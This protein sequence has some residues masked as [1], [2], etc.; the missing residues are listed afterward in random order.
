VADDDADV[1]GVAAEDLGEAEVGA[2]APSEVKIP[3]LEAITPSVLGLK[4]RSRS[5]RAEAASTKAAGNESGFEPATAAEANREAELTA[6]LAPGDIAKTVVVPVSNAVVSI[7]RALGQVTFT[8]AQLPTSKTP[9]TDVIVSVSVMV[10][11]V[12]GAV[13]EVA[14][15]PGD[16]VTLLGANTPDYVQPPLIGAGG[17]VDRLIPTPVDVPLLAPQMSQSAQVPVAAVKAP[18]ATVVPPSN[19]GAVA[20]T[21]LKNELSLSGL[22][23]VRSSISPATTSFLDH[24]VSSVLAPASLTALAAIAL[25]GLGGLLIVCA[26]GIRVGYRQAKAGLALRA[27]G[28]AR[29]AGPGPMGVVRSG[30]LISLHSRTPRLGKPLPARAVRTQNAPRLLESVA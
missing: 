21:G 18:P 15:V 12:V 6:A 27:S 22:A 25:P 14:K 11:S 16:L 23:P 9:V 1:T 8:L 28:I 5:N 7:A 26:A 4:P 29:F 19:I 2:V 10:G 13:V 30:S 17:A 24:V 3:A 20:T